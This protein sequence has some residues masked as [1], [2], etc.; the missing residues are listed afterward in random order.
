M[1]R[2]MK[3]DS[4]RRKRVQFTI[5]HE[6][7]ENALAK[8]ERNLHRSERLANV[9]ECTDKEARYRTLAFKWYHK[10]KALLSLMEFLEEGAL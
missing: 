1:I 5:W 8:A 2:V 3:R 10:R 7:A 9:H 4:D 6:Q